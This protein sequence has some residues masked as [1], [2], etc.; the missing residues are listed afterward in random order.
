VTVSLEVYD[1]DEVIRWALGFADEAWIAAPP[2]AVARAE[3]V[4]AK[5]RLRYT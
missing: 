3:E 2:T 5:M 1:I 4:L